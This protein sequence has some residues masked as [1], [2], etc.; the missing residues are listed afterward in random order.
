VVDRELIL[1]KLGDLDVY[2]GQLA[3]YRGITAER[4]REDWRTQ[5]VIDRTLQI[6]I[7]A[8]LDIAN[9]IIADRQ[10]RAPATYADTFQILAEA[11]VL[12]AS[13]FKR[14]EGVAGFR[15]VLVHEYARLDAVRIARLVNERLDDFAE[16]RQAILA[17]I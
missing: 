8:C 9:H 3:E 12:S 4:Y 17:A 15:N 2:V 16:F 7:E 1:R 10:L 11:G 5:R 14:M 6:A 13:L